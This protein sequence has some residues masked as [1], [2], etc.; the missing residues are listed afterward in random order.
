MRGQVNGAV[1]IE[2]GGMLDDGVAVATVDGRVHFAKDTLT[3]NTFR[4]L[5]TPAGNEPL[6][7]DALD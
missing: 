3:P 4:A 2:P 6:P 1:G 7:D 5:V